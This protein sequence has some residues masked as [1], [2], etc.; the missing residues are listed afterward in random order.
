M[1][2]ELFKPVQWFGEPGFEGI[3]NRNVINCFSRER[4]KRITGEK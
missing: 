4:I 3:P 1:I 2:P